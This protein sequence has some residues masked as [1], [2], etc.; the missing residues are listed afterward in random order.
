MPLK[1]FPVELQREN[2]ILWE[3]TGTTISGGQTASGIIP[4]TRLDGGGLWKATLADVPLVT[5]DQ[6]LAWRAITVYCDGGAQPIIL[7]MCDLRQ[8]PVIEG[9]GGVPIFTVPD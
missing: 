3:L 4:L 2:S 9:A 5:R 8:A 7:P 1:T 6:V